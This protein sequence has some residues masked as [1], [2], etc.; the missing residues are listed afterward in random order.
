MHRALKTRP[1]SW[2]SSDLGGWE[3]TAAPEPLHFGTKWK[4]SGP[5]SAHKNS[6]EL[7]GRALEPREV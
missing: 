1:G 6:G 2:D 5:A 7:E 3:G 4:G